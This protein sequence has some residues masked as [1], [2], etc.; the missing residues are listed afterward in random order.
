MRF[1]NPSHHPLKLER[2][3]R[4]RDREPVKGMVAAISAA[5]ARRLRGWQANVKDV[6]NLQDD[7]VCRADSRPVKRGQPVERGRPI[8]RGRRT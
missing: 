6:Y 2:V 8:G 5:A 4:R 7:V 3:Q 1:A